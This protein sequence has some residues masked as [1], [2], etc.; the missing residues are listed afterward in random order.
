MLYL[1]GA[2]LARGF[3]LMIGVAVR[4]LI[5]VLQGACREPHP[6]HNRLLLNITGLPSMD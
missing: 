3:A 5:L 1:E 6:A 4:G 2:S